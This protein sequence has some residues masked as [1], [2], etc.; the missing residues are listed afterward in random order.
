MK[1]VNENKLIKFTQ[2]LIKI[3]SLP[4]EESQAADFVAE[5]MRGLGFDNVEIDDM[6]NAVGVLKGGH[7]GKTILFDGHLDHVP[8]EP[9]NPWTADPYG[10][11]IKNDR[12][13]GRGTSD[14]KG[15]I[16]GIIYGTG[17]LADI[18]QELHGSIVVSASVCE[19]VAEGIA[20]ESVINKHKPDYVI[21]GESSSLRIAVCQK[22]RAELNVTFKGK[23]AHSSVPEIGHNAI[24]SASWFIDTINSIES[25]AHNLLGKPVFIPIHIT[26]KPSPYQSVVP[27]E[28][29]IVYE[30][31]LIPGMTKDNLTGNF[32]AVIESLKQENP[33]LNAEVSI[34]E[35]EYKTWTGKQFIFQKFIPP[36]ETDVSNELVVR[37]MGGLRIAG[38]P[39]KV[40][41][42]KFCTNG[43]MSA[44]KHGIPTIGFGPGKEEQAHI[45]DEY[46]EIQD[47]LKAAEGYRGIAHSLLFQ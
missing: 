30:I 32:S 7:P 16:A 43:S 9:L 29:T 40:T 24:D 45:A 17:S 41:G 14:M 38:I 39:N 4:G 22:G 26:S 1:Y 23:S 33:S 28:C 46:I 10:A 11:E 6:G 36:W 15:A 37:A 34:I 21:I 20:L 13:Y 3:P 2:S 25:P 44:V 12:I 19:E 27:H 18:K 5:E 8:P 35:S 31:R 42:Y 47:L